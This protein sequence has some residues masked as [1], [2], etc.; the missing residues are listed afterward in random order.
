VNFAAALGFV[1]M[2]AA[3]VIGLRPLKAPLTIPDAIC[4]AVTLVIVAY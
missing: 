1:V 4:L 3:I 2:M